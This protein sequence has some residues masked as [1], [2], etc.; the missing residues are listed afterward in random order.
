MRC[1]MLAD[2]PPP[3]AGKTGWP[4]TV[5]TPQLPAAR[6]DGTPWPRISIV[7]PS[8]NQGRFIEET[9]RSVLLQ[10]YPDL[11]YIVVDGGSTDGAVDMIRNYA[12][13]LTYWTSEPDRGQAHA[14]NKGM[15][16]AKGSI[17]NWLNTDDILAPEA[18]K[19]VGLVSGLRPDADIVG[20]TR[21]VRRL[22][23]TG[24][25]V[26]PVW[27]VGWRDYLLEAGIFAQE[28]TFFS[29][30]AWAAVGPLDERCG[31]IF[32]VI[33]Y[34]KILRSAR[35][36]VL[37]N[38]ILSILCSHDHQKTR[39]KERSDA[40]ENGL[41]RRVMADRSIRYRMGSRLA[42]TRYGTIVLEILRHLRL[43]G[44]TPIEQVDFDWV[45]GTLSVSRLTKSR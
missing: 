26:D 5:E 14:I 34:A 32:D 43:I 27:Q 36:V 44:R 40:Y 21:L 31:F 38:A 29:S 35:R 20:G 28:A 24:L 41:L 3:P 33:H 4:W 13:W 15:A 17:L 11:E 1:P 25:F 10:G 18:A 16:C 22:G 8:Y 39:Q 9:I 7:T 42:A 37:T 6:P 45:A 30:R 23:D 2:L 12:A 19:A